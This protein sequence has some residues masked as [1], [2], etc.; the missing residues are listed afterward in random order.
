[1][2]SAVSQSN[3]MIFRGIKLSMINTIDDD[4]HRM[5]I[6]DSKPTEIINENY[7]G[8]DKLPKKFV[9]KDTWI[10]ST[11]LHCRYCTLTFD[12]MPVIIPET[13]KIDTKGR[14]IYPVYDRVCFCDFPCAVAFIKQSNISNK[15]EKL[16]MLN[17]LY[18]QFYDKKPIVI[19]EPQYSPS[20]L[21]MYGGNKTIAEYKNIISNANK[22]II[23]SCL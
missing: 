18:F 9:N 10:I 5:L 11:N 14:K 17:E 4:F 12:G 15:T 21:E 3:L 20:C 1:M 6:Q 23:F 16:S 22:N 2:L 13:I 8:F 7:L 19:N